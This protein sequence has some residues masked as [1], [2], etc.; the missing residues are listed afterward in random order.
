MTSDLHWW[1]AGDLAAAIRGREVSAR[2]ALEHF[3]ERIERLD[4]PVN[5]VVTWDLER[6]REAARAADDAVHE[7][8]KLG[9]LHGVPITIKDTFADRGL[10]TD[11]GRAASWRRTSRPRTRGRSPRLRAAG[12]IVVR[13]DQ[14]ADLRRR[15]ADLQRGLRH[16]QQPVGRRAARRAVRRAARRRRWRR[17]SRR[18]SSAPT[19]AARS[20]CRRTCAACTGH[21]P[22]YG[23]VPGARPDPRPA[24]HA[25]AGRPQRRRP[26]GAHRRRPGARARRARGPDRW[27]APGLAARAAAGPRHDA[28][29]LPDRGLA[30][31]PVLPD[32]L[33]DVAACSRRR[34]WRIEGAGGR[35]DT[36]GAAWFHAR[37]GRHRASTACSTPRSRAS[38]KPDKIEHLAAN[39]DDTPAGIH[40][41]SD[42]DAPPRLARRQRAPAADAGTVAAVLRALR[43]DPAARPAAG[44]VPARPL[45]AAAAR[46][47][48][49]DGVDAP[50]L[51]PDGWMAPAG[52]GL[53]AGDGGASRP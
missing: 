35:V 29:R 47:V 46:T 16:D 52:A 14:P 7:G 20:G 34:S 51:G 2:E 45:A 50:V 1:T 9:P 25:H 23:I 6:A 30:R 3:V 37:E 27:N 12:A 42:G 5:S 36:R 10:R 41:A 11:V 15:H 39:T 48:A 4:G 19:S 43:R 22:S 38:Y 28:R 40:Q 31:R 13:Q 21:K 24:R 32:R 17:G 44:R 8:D 49:I 18:S 26:D 53:P 33:L